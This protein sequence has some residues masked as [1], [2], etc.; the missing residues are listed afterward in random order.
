MGG[1]PFLAEGK[2]VLPTQD[3]RETYGAAVQL[4]S[5]PTESLPYPELS[6]AHRLCAPLH[7]APYLQGLHTLSQA[8]PVTLVDTKRIRHG[9]PGRLLIELSRLW[10]KP[11]D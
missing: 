5:F 4:L 10:R 8:G 2:I 3:C 7:N 6:S 11:R 9:S 1:T